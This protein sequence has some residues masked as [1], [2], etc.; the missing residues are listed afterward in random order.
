MKK[1]GA[2]GKKNM[3]G[4]I[5]EGV[6]RSTVLIGPNGKIAH[7]WPKVKAEGHAEKVREKLAELRTS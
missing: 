7:H 4:K 6:I 3:Y 2:W 1:Y 5:T